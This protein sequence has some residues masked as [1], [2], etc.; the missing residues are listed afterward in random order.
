MAAFVRLGW[1]ERV[2][3]LLDFFMA[4]RRPAAWNQWAEVI[5]REPRQPRFVG[6]MPHAW[7]A[8]DFL[9]SLYDMFAYERRHDHALVLAAGIPSAW[10]KGEGVGIAHLRTPYGE[11]GYRLR[12]R[13]GQ[14]VLSLP[15]DAAM[16]PGGLV[17]PWP[18]AGQPTGKAWLNG[19]PVAWRNGEIAIHQLPATLRIIR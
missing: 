2:P 10:L 19:Q 3:A 16:P 7:I 12:E 4:D 17:L 13:D 8:S 1:R 6:D 15:A 9:R 14:L 5:G 18:Y 11:L